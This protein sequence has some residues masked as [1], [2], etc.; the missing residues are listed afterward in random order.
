MAA[1]HDDRAGGGEHARDA[2][3][4]R[5]LGAGDLSGGGT[6]HLAHAPPAI[7]PGMHV[8]E[9]AAIRYGLKNLGFAPRGE[10]GRLITNGMSR[11]AMRFPLAARDVV[12][13][14]CELSRSA[15]D[16]AKV[17]NPPSA[18]LRPS[19]SSVRFATTGYAR[20][21][22]SLR[23]VDRIFLRSRFARRN[24]STSTRC[25]NLPT[26]SALSPVWFCLDSPAS[27]QAKEG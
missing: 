11:S 19:V 9:A 6:A 13:N 12:W 14:R 23:S 27:P 26:L 20:S 21:K 16:L 1:R 3:A 24:P 8:R 18:D 25:A 7:H 4:D 10:A 22:N 5:D 17:G 2:A 15:R